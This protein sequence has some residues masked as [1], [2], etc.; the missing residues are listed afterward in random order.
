M[1]QG[2]YTSVAGMIPRINQERSIT[3]NLANQTTYGYKKTDVFLRQLI[4]AQ[5]ALDRASG[6]ER[7][8][9]P[10]S[11]FTNFTQGSFDRTDMPLD[12]ALNGTGFFR[13]QDANGAVHYTRNGRFSLD[14]NGTLVN[15]RGMV[16]LNDRNLP[17][18]LTDRNAQI[19][20]DGTLL[21]NNVYRATIGVADFNPAEIQGLIDIGGG[22]FMRPAAMAEAPRNPDTQVLQG[23]LEDSN[24]EPVLAMVDM[25]EVFRMFELGQQSVQIQDQTLQRVVNELGVVR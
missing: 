7:T 11:V 3:S 8:Q 4:T 6:I 16:L 9:V 19:M 14:P 25:I 5:Y 20:G 10:E 24:V 15:S 17:I 2:L 13:V 21:E 12:L 18:V 22:I 23:Y 1:I